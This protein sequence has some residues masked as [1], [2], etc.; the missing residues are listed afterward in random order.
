VKYF[1]KMKMGNGKWINV[2]DK[3]DGL[4]LAEYKEY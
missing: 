4:G 3:M 2:N 1:W